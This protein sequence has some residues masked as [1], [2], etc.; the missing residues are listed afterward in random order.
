MRRHPCFIQQ[1]WPYG[2]WESEEKKNDVTLT[3]PERKQM[4]LLY[5]PEV[6][7]RTSHFPRPWRKAVWCREEHLN[8]RQAV[9]SEEGV[10]WEVG[11]HLII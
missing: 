11:S 2:A 8:G 4:P 7:R 6:C 9:A 5:L 1:P 3:Y 10:A